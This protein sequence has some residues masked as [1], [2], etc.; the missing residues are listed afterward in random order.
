MTGHFRKMKRN[1]NYT[2]IMQEKK[3]KHALHLGESKKYIY[4]GVESNIKATGKNIVIME[5][6]DSPTQ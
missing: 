3:I 5:N 2:N 1:G 6:K 4:M